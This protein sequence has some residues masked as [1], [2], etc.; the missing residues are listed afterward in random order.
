[1]PIAVVRQ[2]YRTGT[3]SVLRL[4]ELPEWRSYLLAWEPI[5]EFLEMPPSE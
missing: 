1:M 2:H 4:R 3:M 5:R